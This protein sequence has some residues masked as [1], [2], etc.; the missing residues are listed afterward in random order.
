MAAVGE[1][2]ERAFRGAARAF[3]AAWAPP[4]VP[5]APA[6]FG[7]FRPDPAAEQELVAA[8]RA[9]QRT[10]FDR[11]WAGIDWPRLYGG[12][13]GTAVEDAIFRQEEARWVPPWLCHNLGIAIAGPP[14]LEH[15]TEEQRRRLVPAMLAGDAVWCQ[16]FSEPGAGSDLGAVATAAVRDG[17]DWVVNGQKVWSSKA[18]FADHGLLVARSDPAADKYR[19]ITCFT[20]DMRSAGIEVRPIRQMNGACHFN[21]VFLTDV[22]IPAEDVLGDPDRGWAVALATLSGERRALGGLAG[23]PPVSELVA[24]ARRHGATGDRLVRQRLAE[25]DAGARLLDLLGR[26]LGRADIDGRPPGPEGSVGK[27]L[28][29]RQVARTASLGV[30]LQG[31]AGMLA[32]EAAADRGAW[33]SEFTGYHAYSIGGGT[34]EIQRTTIGERVLGLPPEPRPD[35][36]VAFRDIPR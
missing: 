8:G 11:G 7:A 10:K 3:L 20:L 35:K 26:R 29:A 16:L 12:R 14:V 31:P 4:E 27:L 6:A 25:A 33:E 13:G 24:L 28:L 22:R 23:G 30:D 5:G 21:E 19:G 2:E 9:W 1:P 15:G 32:G 18:H 17:R 34:D 36:A